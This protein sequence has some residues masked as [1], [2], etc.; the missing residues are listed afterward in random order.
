[1]NK[2]L[3]VIGIM[4]MLLAVGLSGCTDLNNNDLENSQDFSI[5]DIWELG[6]TENYGMGYWKFY[7]GNFKS[8]REKKPEYIECWLEGDYYVSK[9]ILHVTAEG[10]CSNVDSPKDYWVQGEEYNYEYKMTFANYGETV[11][12]E[13]QNADG[14]T[15][16]HRS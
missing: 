14:K 1:M 10:R 8:F 6:Q 9:H 12:L 3:I 13:N 2:H 15:V 4:L 5:D 11:I 16:L 7:N